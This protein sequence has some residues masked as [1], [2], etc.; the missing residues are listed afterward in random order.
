MQKKILAAAMVGHAVESYDFVVYGASATIIAKNFFPQGNPT[1]AILSTLAVYG[2]SFAVRPLGAAVFGSIGDRHGRRT[3]LSAAVLFM[4]A[5]TALIAVLPGYATA[6]IAAPLL[7]LCCRLVQGVSIGAEYTSAASYVMEQA[8]AH[9]RGLWISTI[10]SATFIGS[11]LASFALLALEK[12]SAAAYATWTWRMAFLLGGAM[13]LVGLYMRLRLD[14]SGTFRDL[15]AAGKIAA[16]PVRDSLRS[17][18]V[19]LLVFAVFA[20]LAVVAQN[21]LGYLP[22]YLM[23]TGGVPG[24]TVLVAGGVTLLV[25]AG[26]CVLAGALVDRVGRKS[27]LISGAVVAVLGSVPAYIL[28]TGGSLAS[29]L[30]AEALLAVPAA[31]IAAPATVMAVELVPSHIRAT[32]SALGYNVANAVFGGTAPFVGALLTTRFGHLAPG[33]YITV[34]AAVILG[35]VF[36][37]LPE[38][39]RRAAVAHG[40]HERSGESA[41]LLPLPE[42]RQSQ[43]HPGRRRPATAWRRPAPREWRPRRPGGPCGRR[44]ARTGSRTPACPAPAASCPP[45][46]PRPPRRNRSSR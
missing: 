8:P 28:A 37:A 27:M 13:A 14:E 41:S 42:L 33:F 15:K 44:T 40:P 29:T 25:C 16:R 31:L 7:L 9:R 2:I 32:S 46:V 30:G 3:A 21:L 23:T 20:L 18:R 34:A 35:V 39:H 36:F 4:A 19:F 24:E 10:G 43:P 26:V 38:T 6:G 1:L 11:A 12:L 45:A 17:W 5:S 22:T